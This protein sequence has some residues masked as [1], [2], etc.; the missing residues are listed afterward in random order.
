MGKNIKKI[1]AMAL[2]LGTVSAVAPATSANILTTKAYAATN[3][4][5]EL[6]SLELETSSGSSIQLYSDDDYKSGNKVDDDEVDEGDEYYARTSSST[7]KIDTD[8]PDDDYIKVFKGTS[9]STKGKDVGKSISLS[10]GK[11]T[12]TV[13]IYDEEPDDNVRYDNDDEDANVIGEYT[14]K[15]KYTGSDSDEEDD[16]AED[17][18]D[19]YLEKLTIA[20]ENISLSDSK[21]TYTY[22]VASDVKEVTI[23][24]EPDYDDYTVRIDGTE[25]DDDEKYKKTVSLATGE[26]KIEV[27]VEDEDEDEERVYTLKITRASTSTTADTTTGTSTTTAANAKTNKW[28]QVNGAWQ[29]NDTTGIPI[30]NSWF[31]DRTLGKEYYLQFNGNMA[32]GWLSNNGVW[33]YLGTDGA[34]KTGWQ[35]VGG[36]WYYLDSQG[37][38]QTGWMKDINGKYYYLNSNGSMA[39][40]TTIA[41]YKLGSDGAWI[42]R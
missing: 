11:N 39:S 30:K 14:I 7:V 28:V 19:I 35:S 40:N 26:N 37:I 42:G 29:Y 9:D 1:V 27:K 12:I 22:N 8:G 4:E 5:D 20:G 34:K 17:Y 32:T 2:V 16:D 15:V 38:M 33:Y 3:T 41:G 31:T 23:K 24:A 10:E 25:V 21:V 6:E 18:D 13:K 36:A